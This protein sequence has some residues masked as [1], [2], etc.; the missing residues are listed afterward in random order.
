MSRRR[1]SPR[2]EPER[3]DGGWNE[4]A[5]Q[6]NRRA[7]M[8]TVRAIQGM[9]IWMCPEAFELLKAEIPVRKE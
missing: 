8:G 5:R 4:S 9:G 6:R 3:F 2:L 1:L 7:V